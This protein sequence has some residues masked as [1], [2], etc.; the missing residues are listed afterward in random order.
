MFAFPKIWFALLCCNTRFE[1]SPFALLPATYAFYNNFLL[2]LVKFDREPLLRLN[3]MFEIMFYNSFDIIHFWNTVLFF[4]ETFRL[5]YK[6][7]DSNS[8][9]KKFI[10]NVLSVSQLNSA[11]VYTILFALS[12]Q[13]I[14]NKYFY[15]MSNRHRSLLE[16]I[17]SL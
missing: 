8:V 12:G 15:Y 3:K 1:I 4:A 5:N 13:W 11:R 7:F 6:D 10:S 9:C 2:L 14:L 17:A 16:H